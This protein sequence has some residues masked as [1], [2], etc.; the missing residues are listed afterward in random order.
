MDMTNNMF[1]ALKVVAMLLGYICFF[2]P[3]KTTN[4][5]AVSVSDW[6]WV[7]LTQL[8]KSPAEDF[9]LLQVARAAT[10]RKQ[11]RSLLKLC[12]KNLSTPVFDLFCTTTMYWCLFF[13]P[14]V[15]KI[16]WKTVFCWVF[17]CVFMSPLWTR[18][19]AASSPCVKAGTMCADQRPGPSDVSWVSSGWSA[20]RPAA[21]R[22]AA[23]EGRK[24]P[25]TLTHPHPS[26]PARVP[27]HT[28]VA[29]FQESLASCVM[30]W[31]RRGGK[32]WGGGSGAE[33]TDGQ[34]RGDGPGVVATVGAVVSSCEGTWDFTHETMLPQQTDYYLHMLKV[35]G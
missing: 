5:Y 15:A 1:A 2:H 32:G 12:L 8:C 19:R 18:L 4:K 26:A 23:G 7:P 24:H 33:K 25:Y 20:V 14:L 17:N 31:W 29:C 21:P 11:A 10:N 6:L 34:R 22:E 9:P 28:P 35:L 16:L 3:H 30:E 13:Q 27:F